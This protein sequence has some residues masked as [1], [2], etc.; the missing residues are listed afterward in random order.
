[1]GSRFRAFLQGQWIYLA[2]VLGLVAPGHDIPVFRADQVQARPLDQWGSDDLALLIEEGQRQVD[3]Q[4]GDLE[5]IRGRAQ[6]LFTLGVAVIAA[7]GGGFV[8]A[9][10]TFVLAAMWLVGLAILV[11]GVAGA[12]AILTVKA[13]FRVIHAAVLSTSTPPIDQALA[14]SYTRMMATGENTVATRLTVFRQAVVF[15]LVGGCLGLLAV[16]LTR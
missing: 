3:R 13:D 12:A 11:Y 6:W 4:Q 5:S 10:P 14:S 9:R 1:V 16:L 15:C 7:L 8:S 2:H